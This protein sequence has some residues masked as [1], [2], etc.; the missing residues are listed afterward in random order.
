MPF[1]SRWEIIYV[2]YLT[3]IMDQCLPPNIYIIGA[4]CTGKTTLVNALEKHFSRAPVYFDRP[5][6]APGILIEVARGVL[7]SYSFTAADIETSPSKALELQSL[8]LRAQ[9]EAESALVDRWFVS[10]RSGVDT[11]IYAER[12]GGPGALNILMSEPGWKRTLRR[13]RS[14]VIVVCEA[15][16]PWLVDDGTRLMPKTMADWMQVH[17]SFCRLLRS[18]GLGFAV[19][20][21][22]L[23]ALDARVEFVVELWERNVAANATR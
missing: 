8:I 11:A 17:D 9:D 19:L 14:A 21:R 23:T 10:D 1:Y 6:P 13:M 2:K 16:V 22:D 18:F 3:V 15:G 12:F 20:P 5:T 4:Q 7:R